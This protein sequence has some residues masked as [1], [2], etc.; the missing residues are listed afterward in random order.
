M[1]HPAVLIKESCGLNE[2]NT[3]VVTKEHS[4][5]LLTKFYILRSATSKV[6][7]MCSDRI[8]IWSILLLRSHSI[9]MTKP[10][11]M[12]PLRVLTFK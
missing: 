5:H 10:I 11:I 2:S 12:I 9:T 6:T 7:K 8:I 4:F 1:D 3:I